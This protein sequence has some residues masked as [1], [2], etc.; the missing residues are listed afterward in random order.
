MNLR[1]SLLTSLFLVTSFYTNTLYANDEFKV[2][3]PYA[4][5]IPGI[6]IEQKIQNLNIS[7][8]L[9]GERDEIQ[10][11]KDLIKFTTKLAIALKM[12][13]NDTGIPIEF[14]EQDFI[15][16][17]E[18][19]AKFKVEVLD[20]SEQFEISAP[21]LKGT[22]P[23]ID[24]RFDFTGPNEDFDNQQMR[25]YQHSVSEVA[26]AVANLPAVTRS[27]LT[28]TIEINLIR[29]SQDLAYQ[30]LFKPDFRAYQSALI[31]PIGTI[32][33]FPKTIE[34]ETLMMTDT[35]AHEAGHIWSFKC[36]S[37]DSNS[38][39]WKAWEK[40]RVL[41]GNEISEYGKSSILEDAAEMALV[42][43]SLISKGD[44]QIIKRFS[45]RFPNRWKI[46]EESYPDCK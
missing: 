29:N 39:Q 32:G 26:Q 23:R 15:I 31:F 6:H 9:I 38:E 12:I 13:P 41:D 46:I 33:I 42:Y 18:T 3:M 21:L 4:Q 43:A 45:E 40:A 37:L 11:P 16:T 10:K 1:K 30:A 19:V 7:K 44:R 27:L 34:P 20:S 2:L 28:N 35:L 14:T 5:Y 36:F 24:Q 25:F 17:K 8:A 22:T